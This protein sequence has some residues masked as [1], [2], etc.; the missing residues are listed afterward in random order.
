MERAGNVVTREELLREV[1]N[2]KFDPGTKLI[3]VHI[4]LLRV[5]ID[6][7]ETEPLIKTVRGFGYLIADPG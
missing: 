1:W 3:D 4:R 5:K 2:L 7:G 6:E